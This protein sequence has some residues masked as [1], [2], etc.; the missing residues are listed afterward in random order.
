MHVN[1]TVHDNGCFLTLSFVV[2]DSIN[3]PRRSK[4]R[5]IETSFGPYFL[6]NFLIE[7]FA[8]V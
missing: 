3:E 5:R 2:I 4:R 1:L 8:I 6:M 7:D